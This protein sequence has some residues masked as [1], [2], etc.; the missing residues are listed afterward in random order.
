M[1]R[2]TTPSHTLYYTHN[3]VT[4][5]PQ[6][7]LVH[8]AADTHMAWPPE[9]RRLQQM[10]VYALDLPGHGRSAAPHCTSVA[11]MA[12]A[13]GEFVA[14]L[15]LSRVVLVGHSMGGAIGQL[16]AGQQPPWLAG[17]VLVT[18]AAR[19]PV[20]PKLIAQ[21]LTDLP[22]AA[23]FI[24]KYSWSPGVDEAV[25]RAAEQAIIQLAPQV[26]HDDFVA[27]HAFDGTAVLGRVAV[28]TLVIG[29]TQ[30]RMIAVRESELLQEQ[31]AGAQLLIIDS[32]H[33][34]AL[35]QRANTA[36][37]IVRFAEALPG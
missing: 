27:C 8:G 6:L 33:R 2:I 15:G 31:I 7:L 23:A 35:E 24:V 22:G 30:D 5:D 3:G 36:E 11:E 29:A 10:G 34:V 37:A 20:N 1:P 9:L 26:V 13:V 16:V 25:K 14:A 28:P 12:T 19:L 32:S 21:T 17:L 4:S 18:T